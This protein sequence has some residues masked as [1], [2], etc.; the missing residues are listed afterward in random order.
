ML[1]C[2][3]SFIFILCLH[4]QVDDALSEIQFSQPGETVMRM[5]MYQF[6]LT[7]SYTCFDHVVMNKCLVWRDGTDFI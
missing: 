2:Q 6:I 7:K 4:G 1:L 5:L 3:I